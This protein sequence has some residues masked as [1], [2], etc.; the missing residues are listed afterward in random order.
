MP[1]VSGETSL[2]VLIPVLS[3]AGEKASRSGLSTAER[4][5]TGAFNLWDGS[6]EAMQAFAPGS[7][8]T[9][10]VP[11]TNGSGSGG[12]SVATA[13]GVRTTVTP[14]AE[15]AITLD[16]TRTEFE[17]VSRLLDAL[18]VSA[19]VALDAGVPV[20]CGFGAS[21]AA[22][23]GSALAANA[24]FGLGRRLE[25]LVEAAHRAEVAAGTG[26]GDV[27]VQ[28]A[29]GLV[30]D[31]GEGRGRTDCK[32]RV[33][34]TA[35]GGIDT[36][37]VLGDEEL[38]DRIHTEGIAALADLP[39]TPTLADA[40]AR[41]WTFAWQVGLPTDRL[42]DVVED[43][44][45]AGGIATMAMVGETVVGLGAGDVLANETSVSNAGARVL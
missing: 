15:S 6:F 8:T 19:T 17:P 20:G 36:A 42:R 25:A 13:D 24:E 12:V 29:G 37:S 7:V 28:D 5:E 30:Y 31:V 32:K 45:A 41:C 16:G 9:V 18:G 26:L 27:F 40:L 38:L 35:F 44:E 11:S 14:A 2:R 1:S 21:G 3:A 4:P 22:T 39:A 33:G 10:F 43:V 23:L 34:Y